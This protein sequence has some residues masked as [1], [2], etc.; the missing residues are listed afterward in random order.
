L[1]VDAASVYIS[2]RDRRL[3]HHLRTPTNSSR[4]A[5]AP[6]SGPPTVRWRHLLP[7]AASHMAWNTK[8]TLIGV[9][10]DKALLLRH[11]HVKLPELPI[12]GIRP[13]VLAVDKSGAR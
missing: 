11:Q 12:K 3:V 2:D 8:H 13:T 4:V 6:V 7:L 10:R 1:A 5:A 9:A